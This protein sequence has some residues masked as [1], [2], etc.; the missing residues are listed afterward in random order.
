MATSITV[1]DIRDRAAADIV[2][3]NLRLRQRV[4]L[5]E[6]FLKIYQEDRRSTDALMDELLDE[7]EQLETLRNRHEVV[8]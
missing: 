6:R 2:A 1:R 7:L 8:A 4:V 5:L 3:E